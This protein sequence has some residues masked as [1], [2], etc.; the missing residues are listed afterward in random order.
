M[1]KFK[2]VT[3]AALSGILL[4]CG[5][6]TKPTGSPQSTS[7]SLD[8]SRAFKNC[9]EVADYARY[10]QSTKYKAKDMPSSTVS[11]A[12]ATTGINTNGL[13][14]LQE[15][16]TD[17]SDSVKMTDD[18]VFVLRQDD[19]VVTDR[20][21]WKVRGSIPIN[22]RSFTHFYVSEN[23]LAI[24]TNGRA[25]NSTEVSFYDLKPG[26]MPA[27]ATTI[28]V[29]G[30]ITDSRLQDGRLLIILQ[31]SIPSSVPPAG[32]Q[33]A[34]A[35]CD[36]AIVP[37]IPNQDAEENPPITITSIQTL[38]ISNNGAD[39]Q[40][41]NVID[42]IDHVYVA[43]G[44][45]FLA[46][47]ILSTPEESHIRQ[48]TVD[49]KTGG[50]RLLAAGRVDGIANGKWAFKYYDCKRILAVAT[51]GMKRPQTGQPTQGQNLT[52][53]IPP[54]TNR[55]NYLHTL[56]SIGGALK[57]LGRLDDFG[58][59]EDIRAVR[60][61][62]ETAYVVTFKRTDPLYPIDISNI[63]APR[64][65]GEL[66]VPGFSTMLHP[67]SKDMVVGVG[68]DA[69]DSESITLF[70]GV[71]ISVFDVSDRKNPTE[72][73]SRI[74]GGR[75][76]SSEAT[77]DHHAFYYD[78]KA[79]II[80]LPITEYSFKTPDNGSFNGEFVSSG[81]VFYQLSE[82]HLS[83]VN[84]I[85]HEDLMPESCKELRKTP[86]AS[87]T[88]EKITNDVRRIIGVNDKVLTISPFGIKI[89]DQNVSQIEK[90]IIFPNARNSCFLQEVL[91]GKSD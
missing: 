14:N 44:Q 35:R 45:I 47:S 15:N 49:K 42:R 60:Y 64:L 74:H 72:K 6:L 54:I 3:A 7:L 52:M 39:R 56:V 26:A 78:A 80:G 30:L 17:E 46:K 37:F 69:K 65:L 77:F 25:R 70:Q 83:E 19:I 38:K 29:P 57:V 34:G 91:P 22:P 48:I 10:V 58:I 12:I 51:S 88:Q 73:D 81:T 50:L 18:A 82:G 32:L 16:G 62:D 68:F 67:I 43:L 63:G 8:G 2:F 86:L 53:A 84:R 1:R 71:K 21:T 11:E 28:S 23:K 59:G 5:S 87:W 27:S 36:Q 41:L 33:L 40:A 66:K 61:I 13:T 4:S 24:I 85:S 55:T 9:A 20:A 79:E 75:G 76:G 90:N 89:L 31:N